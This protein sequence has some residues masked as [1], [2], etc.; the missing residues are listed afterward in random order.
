MKQIAI[1]VE[2]QTEEQF[3]K[4]ILFDYFLKKD[5]CVEPITVKT[6]RTPVCSYRGG[7]ITFEKAKK[8]IQRLL[9]PKYDKVTTFFDYY[10]LECSFFPFNFDKS[11]NP[12]DKVKKLEDY[13]QNCINNTKF[14]P[15]IQLHEFETFLFVDADLTVNNLI[16]CNKKMVKQEIVNAL[17]ISDNNPELI[18][19]SPQTAPS[20]RIENVHPSY[21]KPLEGNIVCGAVGLEVLKNKCKHFREWIEKLEQ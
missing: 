13:F 7:T 10:G 4:R 19:D 3:V 11:L 2:G 8:E 1:L 5:I 14:L 17:D 16:N 20:K 9:T 12:Y 18:N 15:Y 21:Q 6:S